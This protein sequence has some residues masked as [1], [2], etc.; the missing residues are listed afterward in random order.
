MPAAY[1]QLAGEAQRLSVN[2]RFQE[3]SANLDNKALRDVERVL[4][5]LKTQ[6][7]LQHAVVLVG[8]GDPKGSPSR[9]ALLSKLRAMAVRR[10]L[11]KGGVI[12]RDIVG[13]GD[14]LS[15]AGNDEEGRL[16][17]RRVE[18]WVY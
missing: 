7:K 2:F 3:D 11:A 1:R 17:N 13:L 8:F 14:E 6:N 16:K 10:E 12:F 18:V 9:T 5:Y 4:D 15:V